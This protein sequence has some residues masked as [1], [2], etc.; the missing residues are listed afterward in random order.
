MEIKWIL[1][2][3]GI[4]WE[5]F[6]FYP[7]ELRLWSPKT[8]NIVISTVANIAPIKQN[9]TFWK[10]LKDYLMRFLHVLDHRSKRSFGNFII[11]FSTCHRIHYPFPE[12]FSRPLEVTMHSTIVTRH[13]YVKCD[14]ISF[15]KVFANF[16]FCIHIQWIN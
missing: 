6:P 2:L 4:M 13:L 10:L 1:T 3:P 7:S 8:W 16:A 9:Q 11:A 12:I 14:N 15:Y 5:A